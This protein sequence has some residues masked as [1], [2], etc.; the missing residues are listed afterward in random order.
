M[1]RFSLV[2]DKGHSFESW[3]P[4]GASYEKQARR[5]LI[6]C[7]EC[8]S[9]GVAKA[10][11]APAVVGAARPQQEEASAPVPAPATLSDARE[12]ALRDAL[13]KLKREIEAHT[14]D[15]GAEF[16]E[17]ARAIHSG[18]APERAIRGQATRAEIK[19]LIDEG[20]G[21]LPMPFVPDEFN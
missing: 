17:A 7:P 13:R 6:A 5:G 19:A 9:T 8:G 16:P 2:C 20:V 4:D 21:V 3:F 1:I 11:M 12:R 14:D 15:V 18:E 10:V